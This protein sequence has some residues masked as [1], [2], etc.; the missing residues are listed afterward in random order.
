M[1]PCNT[2]HVKRLPSRRAVAVRLPEDSRT[3]LLLRV[4]EGVNRRFKGILDRGLVA[5]DD[6]TWLLWTARL[7]L[8]TVF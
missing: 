1:I 4:Y 8:A 3:V 5:T 2:R 6:R 7:M